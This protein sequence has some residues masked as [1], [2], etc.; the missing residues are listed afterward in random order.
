[1]DNPLH[2]TIRM[3]ALMLLNIYGVEEKMIKDNPDGLETF[4]KI[5]EEEI[6]N[7]WNGEACVIK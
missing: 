7:Y 6:S 1:M 3:N 2:E 4:I 5:I